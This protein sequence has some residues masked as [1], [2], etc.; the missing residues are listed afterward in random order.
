M[1]L[2]ANDDQQLQH[3]RRIRSTAVTG[4]DHAGNTADVG[5]TDYTYLVDE[6]GD[7]V[8]TWTAAMTTD[9][10]AIAASR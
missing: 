3:R 5:H 6:L 2:R 10:L 4:H 7:V 8:I 9:D 1:P